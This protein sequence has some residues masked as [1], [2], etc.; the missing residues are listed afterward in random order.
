MTAIGKYLHEINQLFGAGSLIGLLM[1]SFGFWMWYYRIQV[2]QDRLLKVQV[3][4]AERDA[5]LGQKPCP[6]VDTP[7]DR[8]IGDSNLSGNDPQVSLPPTSGPV[9]GSPPT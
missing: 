1:A 6:K 7:P 9:E 2:F 4:A 3:Q 5:T 8:L